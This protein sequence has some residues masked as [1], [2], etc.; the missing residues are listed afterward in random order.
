MHRFK[1][2]GRTAITLTVFVFIIWGS[3]QNLTID[4][5]NI[6]IKYIASLSYY[7]L[8]RFIVVRMLSY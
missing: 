1:F 3:I 5:R 8:L 7:L 2:Y 4:H 6:A